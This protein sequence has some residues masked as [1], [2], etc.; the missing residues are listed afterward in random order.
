MRAPRWAWACRRRSAA[1]AAAVLATL[2]GLAASAPAAGA[3]SAGQPVG[4]VGGVKAA[5]DRVEFVFSAT[6][7]PAETTVDSSRVQ[8]TLGGT[9]V[10]ATARL[11]ESRT[12]AA[13]ALPPRLVMMVFDTS[14][15]MAGGK[16][17]DARRAA[18]QFARGLPPDVLVGLVTFADKPHVALRPTRDRARLAAALG[19]VGPRGGSALYDAV[20]VA[21]LGL[22]AAK[23][24][25]DA[26]LRVVVLSDGDDSASHLTLADALSLLRRSGVPTDVVAFRFAGDK[27]LRQI[28]TATGGRVLPATDAH[29]LA[30]AFKA[31]ART[32]DQRLVVTAAV[33]AALAGRHVR[34]EARVGAG[35]L[36]LRAGT[37]VSLPAVPAPAAGGGAAGATLPG[38]LVPAAH[39]WLR[40][41]VLGLA[42]AAL[43]ALGLVF[44]ALYRSPSDRRRIAEL[45]RYR[46]VA[47]AALP[48]GQTRSPV[49][50]AALSWTERVV[51]ARGVQQS[52]ALELDRA[53][54]AL[55]VQEWM[56]LRACGSA[57]LAAVLVLLTGSV[58]IGLP[59]GV[60]LGWLGSRA[61]LAVRASRRCGAFAGQLPDVLQLA[62]SSLRSGFS[63][64][65]ALEGVVRDGSQPVAGEIARALAQARLGV[66]L[67]DALD[68]VAHRMRSRDLAW[69]VMA[70]RIQREVG[71]NLAEIL[72]TTVQ[73]MRERAQL[74]RQVRTLTAEGRLSAYILVALPILV[75]C[76]L[77]LSRG[78][79]MRPLYTDPIG[80]VMLSAAI[81]L[82]ALG[83]FW[84]SRLVKVEV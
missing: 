51:T 56:L 33:P 1:A 60:G 62:A 72:L 37:D 11:T 4:R 77:F 66:D 65:Q 24:P 82:V 64:P 74:R 76:W 55:R 18:L 36:T 57:G 83:A 50:R 20:T 16:L 63:L 31:A 13:A 43:L 6:N 46:I 78:E 81:L 70:I 28:A 52:V 59:V 21:A 42:F 9:P 35:P 12:Q 47:A 71:G 75:G 27:A 40:W 41:V 29:G 53:G 84:L 7:L 2:A 26:V 10:S 19:G 17:A 58:L 38:H 61:Y 79:Y 23:S 22:R 32:L 49:A 54:V 44:L 69:T 73:T 5:A 14:G 8:V 30:A 80:V 39:D 15:S 25:A 3:D 67:E 68:A 34:L 48:S 45:A